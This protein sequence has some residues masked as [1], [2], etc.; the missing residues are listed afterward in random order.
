MKA[1]P[2]WLSAVYRSTTSPTQG[3]RDD[4]ERGAE[5]AGRSL[6]L[7]EAELQAAESYIVHVR[8]ARRKVQEHLSQHKTILAPIRR[9]PSEILAEIF[10]AT[11][12]DTT[13]CDPLDYDEMPW[14]LGRVCHSWRMV[15]ESTPK[16]WSRIRVE[17]KFVSPL[18]TRSRR[19]IDTFIQRAAQHPLKLEIDFSYHDTH[20]IINLLTA[21]SPQWE[22]VSMTLMNVSTW[23]ALSPIR[24][25]IPMLRR[26][27]L[28]LGY[29]WCLPSSPSLSPS[30]DHFSVAPNLRYL[31]IDPFFPLRIPWN[32]LA[33]LITHSPYPC[34]TWCIFALAGN[35]VEGDISISMN[36]QHL[37]PPAVEA[38]LPFMRTLT[39]RTSCDVIQ[40]LTMPLIREIWLVDISLPNHSGISIP[41][42]S[43][44]RTLVFIRVTM[45]KGV[46]HRLLQ[47]AV[48]VVQ[49]VT[50]ANSTILDALDEQ[51]GR[52]ISL[53]H[54]KHLVLH[55]PLTRSSHSSLLRLL[56]SRLK[57]RPQPLQIE[58]LSFITTGQPTCELQA[59]F[60]EY[61][62]KG[63]KIYC[64]GVWPGI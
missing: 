52:F 9:I 48:S 15:T 12:D 55:G 4:A 11:I 37:L 56:H 46:Y 23:T 19:L 26:L 21:C 44:L 28:K 43:T 2:P 27:S 16:L 24:D 32:Q 53:P 59:S 58:S 30:P 31:D 29:I 3:Q 50:D 45:E 41:S 40:Y 1:P 42:Y 18:A 60:S 36:Q 61:A 49:L 57:L 10:V 22:D 20:P 5:K 54:L 63:M 62:A 8:E 33:R 39:L 25:R 6:T 51:P 47:S 34:N 38:R 35:V 64:D 17:L 13:L 7:L 14:L